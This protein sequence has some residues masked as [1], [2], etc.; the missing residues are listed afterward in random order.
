MYD[1]QQ[2][3]N[4]LGKNQDVFFERQNYPLAVQVCMRCPVMEACRSYADHI[5]SV[6]FGLHGVWGG[7]TPE[8]RKWRRQEGRNKSDKTGQLVLQGTRS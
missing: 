1:W 5:E 3:A 7:E 4:C 6:T 2:E 8:Q